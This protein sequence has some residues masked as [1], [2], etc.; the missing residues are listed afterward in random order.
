MRFS[1]LK[2]LDPLPRALWL[3]VV[4]LAVT[5]VAAAIFYVSHYR[6]QRLVVLLAAI[7]IS[8]IVSKY[9]LRLP[10]TSIEVAVGD[11]IVIW[12]VFWL[13]VSGGVLLGAAA[14][15]A[16]AGRDG[17]FTLKGKL[18]AACGTLAAGAA[19][20]SYHFIYGLDLYREEH[21]YTVGNQDTII[22]GA[23]LMTLVIVI[24]RFAFGPVTAI[25]ERNSGRGSNIDIRIRS[26]AIEMIPVFL[27]SVTLVGLF[28]YFGLAFGFVVL[29]CSILA[30]L[31]YRVHLNSL[32]V[33]TSQI[34][35]ASRIQLATVEALATAIDARD[36]VGNGHVRRTQI[37]AVGLGNALG[38]SENEINALR[39]GALLHD[40]GKLAVPDHILSKPGQLTAAELE[41]TK[42]HSVVGAS[43]LEKVGF[44]YPVVPAVR[45]HHECWDG[46]GYPDGLAGED[47]P[48]TARILAIADTYDTLRSDRPFRPAKSAEEARGMLQQGAGTQFDP[49]IVSVFLK[50]LSSLDAQ[51]EAQGLG[52]TDRSSLLEE[53]VAVE[54]ENY[55]EQI[56][57]ANKEVFTLYEL[58]RD[59]GS[60]ANLDEMLVLFS[61]HV[62]RLV[63]FDTFVVYLLDASKRSA[64]AAHVSG[65]NSDLLAKRHIKVGKGATGIALKRRQMVKNVNP[66]LDFSLSHLELIQQY[67]T[68]AALPLIADDEI[69]GAVSIYS[70]DL[71]EY[72][73]EH[74]RL[75]ETVSRIAAEAIGKTQEHAEAKANALTDP[76]TGLPNAR[77]LQFQFEKE[78]GRASRSGSTFQV[79]VMDLDGFKAINDNYGHIAG[80]EMLREVGAVIQA[81][82][83]DYDFFA[84]YGGD[85]F[86]ALIPDA[87]YGDVTDLCSRIESAVSAF[88]LPVGD[89]NFASVGVSLGSAGYPSTGGTFDELIIAADKAMYLQKSARKLE[90]LDPLK[91]SRAALSEV[92]NA[93]TVSRSPLLDSP[94]SENFII[95]LDESHVISSAVN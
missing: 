23:I 37:Y 71:P 53:A 55:I 27:F 25:A 66:D 12:G 21:L 17:K 75:L 6:G 41:K 18:A 84:R 24:A 89:N 47:I 33:K 90:N 8:T 60:S 80:D 40:I 19:G 46:T 61:D 51:V 52:Y 95:E 20:L 85:E 43:I 30:V 67:S 7:F 5:A 11:I 83:R 79:L 26:R 87:G 92:L 72:D 73:E 9:E 70:N 93:G 10:K 65:D 36:Q 3:V 28:S 88:K 39:S 29:P 4:S 86:V 56:K 68:M 59:F 38:L 13:G 74:L 1:D 48:K 44:N 69:V 77:S 78:I 57:L 63:P 15:I 58:A 14:S 31:S 16:K 42:V 22:V 76:M 49:N 64:T 32:A 54:A 50:R 82:L 94:T 62:R 2:K 91:H 35:E 45:H 34:M 81:Q